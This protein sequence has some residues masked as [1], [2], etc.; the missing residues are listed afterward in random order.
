LALIL[1]TKRVTELMSIYTCPRIELRSVP[2]DRS[3]LDFRNVSYSALL[4]LRMA[5]RWAWTS[6]V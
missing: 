3:V 4:R 6:A 2:G 5:R 1:Y